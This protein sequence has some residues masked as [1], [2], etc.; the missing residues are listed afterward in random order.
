MSETMFCRD[1]N[2]LD[3]VAA[4]DDTPAFLR[5][6]SMDQDALTKAIIG[7]I[8]DVDSYQLPDAKG[9]TAFMRHLLGVTDEERQLRREQILSTSN[10]DFRDF[11][12]VLEAVRGPAARVVAVTSKGTVDK[13]NSSKDGFFDKV[14]TVV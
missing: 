14:T 6:V 8:G 1:P 4:Y 3:T 5:E 13:V 9:R 2:L 12:E 7:T 11:A 10:K